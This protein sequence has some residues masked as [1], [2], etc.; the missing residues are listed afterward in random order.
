[1]SFLLLVSVNFF[2]ITLCIIYFVFFVQ[3]YSGQCYYVSKAKVSWYVANSDCTRSEGRLANL[4][5]WDVFKKI[6]PNPSETYWTGK[7][8]LYKYKSCSVLFCPC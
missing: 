1:M 8:L 6:V 3:L 4:K 7:L 2:L 5:S